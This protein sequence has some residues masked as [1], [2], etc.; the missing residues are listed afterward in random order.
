[1]LGPCYLGSKSQQN[2]GASQDCIVTLSLKDLTALFGREIGEVGMGRLFMFAILVTLS[3]A[4]LML[5]AN[6]QGSFWDT[7]IDNLNIERSTI[8]LFC[9]GT[10]KSALAAADSKPEPITNLS[11]KVNMAIRS[12]T[13]LQNVLAITNVTDTRIEFWGKENQ[14]ASFEISGGMNRVTGSTLVSWSNHD[15][16]LTCLPATRLF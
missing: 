16:E 1:V 4:A 12:V 11:I 10:D 14:G 3:A 15:W 6:A 8:T 9:N 7:P 5:P 13:I 2:S